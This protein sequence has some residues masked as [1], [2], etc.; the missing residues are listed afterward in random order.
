MKTRVF[1]ALRSAALYSVTA[2][3]VLLLS[4]PLGLHAYAQEAPTE[5]AQIVSEEP[6]AEPVCVPPEGTRQPTGSTALTYKYNCDTGLW[7]NKYYTWN[8][9]NSVVTARY[10]PEHR[11][12]AERNLWEVYEWIYS[13]PLGDYVYIVTQ[14]Y[15]PAPPPAPATDPTTKNTDQPSDEPASTATQDP[16][17][18]TAYLGLGSSPSTLQPL[19]ISTYGLGA[20]A[21]F[22]LSLDADITQ[23]LDSTAVS[24]DA[25]VLQNTSAGDATSGDASAQANIINMIQ[26]ALGVEGVT[27]QIYTADIQGDYYG[28]IIIDPGA[29]DTA[30]YN[31][32]ACNLNIN[33]EIDASIE[34]NVNLLASSGDATVSSN[35]SAGDATSGDANAVAN[36]VNM[37]S[38]SI[39]AGESFIGVLN[40]HGNLEGDVLLANDVINELIAANVPTV[41]ISLCD[42]ELSAELKDD[43]TIQ[44]NI[45]AAAGSGDATVAS[46]TTAGNATSGDATTSVTVFNLTGRT[47]VGQDAILVFVN[48]S[49]QW[50]GFITNAP[51]GATAAVI[52]GGLTEN[53]VNTSGDTE[54]NA[55][56][57]AAIHN[58][59]NVG[60]YSGDAEVSNNTMAGN[61]TSGDASASV[62]VANITN[63]TF[64]LGGWFGLLFINI[65]GDWHGSFGTD[66]AYGG[67]SQQPPPTVVQTG[68]GGVAATTSGP[69]SISR[70]LRAFA[71]SFGSDDSGN[72][73][74]TTSTEMSA[75]DVAAAVTDQ[76]FG[77]PLP[78]GRDYTL[79]VFAAIIAAG[80][81]LIVRQDWIAVILRRG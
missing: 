41:D 8:P 55:D 28:D 58:N 67:Y 27:P 80:Y 51:A 49:G 75:D 35:T 3:Q 25:S 5:P 79:L 24:G 77:A 9:V 50:V 61:A 34:N 76:N 60:A 78:T 69:A 71:V 65:F 31:D 46:N 70:G 43:L 10:T 54:I 7:E 42:C 12:N 59:I 17:S 45:T 63:S 48:V 72:A 11:F 20:Q 62:N 40:V 73:V 53:S 21:G 14:T 26:S 37:I 16:L 1:T 52:G 19:S 47:I 30:V 29:F 44:N 33:A 13:A 56:T 39:A 57:N 64:S 74:L 15:A 4:F 6:A 23:N 66:T 2:L 18:S 68:V 32:C 81:V 22:D 36:I 38:S